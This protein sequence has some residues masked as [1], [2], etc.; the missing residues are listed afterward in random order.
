MALKIR[1][2]A[3]FPA[4]VLATTGL[5][6]TK[7]NGV[8]TFSLDSGSLSALPSISVADQDNIFVLTYNSEGA[9]TYARVPISILVSSVQ[10][11]LD[12]TL[13]A[14]GG[15]SPTADQ[16]IY[17]T[18]ADAAALATLTAQ[19]R[20][21]LDD[22]TAGDM[23]TTLG[24]SAF[25]QTILDDAD[26]ATVRATIGA[27]AS[28]ANT[29]ITSI[30]LDNTGLKIKDTNASHGLIIAPGSNLTADRTLTITTG[31]APRTINVGGNLTTAADASIPAIAQGDVLYG[32]AAGALSALA[33]N[34][35]ATRYLAN[36]GASNNPAW[37]QVNLANGV[38]GN[39]PVAN[40]GSGTSASSSTFWRGDGSWA[41]PAAT[42]ANPPTIQVFTAS[43]TW[44]KPANLAAA[45]VVAVG[46]G[47]GGGGIAATGASQAASA[48]GGGSGEYSL[49]RIV[50]ASL[51]ATETV[52]IGAAGA[53]GASGNNAGG[54]GGNTSFGAHVAANGGTGGSGNAGSSTP[55]TG[56]NG[57]A[58]G[59]G[60]AGGDLSIPGNAGE[61]GL[62]LSSSAGAVG[63]AGAPGPFG[64]AA[65]APNTGGGAVAGNAGSRGGGGSGAVSGASQSAQAG[66]A[67][68][69]GFI[70]VYEFY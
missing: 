4:R 2:L 53:A 70:I 15:L 37:A 12:A 7:A 8:W 47:G 16:M 67:G 39:L 51:G 26:A 25:V 3:K 6:I 17:F 23:L 55:G 46:G 56:G 30:Y 35:T 36:T 13:V 9:P 50:A 31:D 27:A 40:L 24:V 21:L 69:A 42:S 57:G 1:A 10:E 63:G 54:N 68:G 49:K 66:G 28:G 18:G 32:S 64:G 48:G 44:T 11:G 59:T 19:G 38:T 52:T 62:K 43:G 34:T 33:K 65:A 58:G 20:A 45:M 60:G 29:D 22:A 14:I 61:L 41:T 5:A